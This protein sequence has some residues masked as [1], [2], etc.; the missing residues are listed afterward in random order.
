VTAV[1]QSTP[2]ILASAI[3]IDAARAHDTPGVSTVREQASGGHVARREH[4]R[5]LANETRK[6]T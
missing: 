3:A 2:I 1:V 6:R 5:T 4:R